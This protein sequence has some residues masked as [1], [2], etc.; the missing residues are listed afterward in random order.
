MAIPKLLEH[1]RKLR[2]IKDGTGTKAVIE[3]NANEASG[4]SSHAEGYG[5]NASGRYSH[6]EGLQS[7]SIGNEGSHAEGYYT[8]AHG[9]QGSHA[10]GHYTEAHGN[11]GSHAEG[12]K[13]KATGEH[14]HA[15]GSNTRSTEVASHTE[16]EGTFVGHQEGM[17]YVRAPHAEGI[18]TAA[19]GTGAHAEG[20]YSTPYETASYAD[21]TISGNDGDLTYQIN[22]SYLQLSSA[23]TQRMLKDAG[24]IIAD[25]FYIVTD[26]NFTNNT[27]TFNTS[28]GKLTNH[29]ITDFIYS[30]AYGDFTHAE[31]QGTIATGEDQHVQGSWNIVDDNYDYA[32]IVGNGSYSKR[33]NAHTVGWDGTGWFKGD[34]YVGSTSGTNKDEGSKKLATEEYVDNNGGTFQAIYKTT[35]YEEIVTAYN[36]GKVI[37]AHISSDPTKIFDLVTAPNNNNTLYFAVRDSSTPINLSARYV[38]HI[39]STSS[40]G[41]FNSTNY[42]AAN[43][44][45]YQRD[46]EITASEGYYRPIRVSLN[47]PTASDGKVGDIWVVY[48][49]E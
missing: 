18:Y 3:S 22:N 2:N 20:G 23:V 16:G 48:S 26:V 27:I 35:T 39:N 17:A 4:H 13:T 1:E 19:L 6:A 24:I 31:G 29:N 12:Y 41:A 30:Q 32:H 49:N 42:D 5:S 10:E 28:P 25:K 8:E 45:R 37:T 7:K 46:T 14:S 36:Q 44:I 9:Y 15:E 43:A 47:P 34:V 21:L 11:Q 40:W 33:S 38:I